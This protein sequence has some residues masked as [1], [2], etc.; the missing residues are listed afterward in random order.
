M[1]IAIVGLLGWIG[2]SLFESNLRA[3]TSEANSQTL[4]LD[5]QTICDTEGKLLVGDRDICPKA[6]SVL[7]NPTEAIAGPKGEPGTPGRDGT[8]GADS[9]IPGPRGLEGEDGKDS[10][11]P[12]PPGAPGLDSTAPGPQGMMGLSGKDG[13]DGADGAPGADSTVPGPQGEAGPAGPQGPQGPEGRGVRSQNC[14]DDGRWLITY[15]DGEVSDGGVC[16]T[17]ITPPIGGTP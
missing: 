5:I 16:R 12:G 13:A 4:A 17:T 2:Y 7:A 14:G 9:T 10:T 1:A 11:V 15:T 8:P 3:A 6:D